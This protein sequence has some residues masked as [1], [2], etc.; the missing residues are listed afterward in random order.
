[1]YP[2]ARVPELTERMIAA[3]VIVELCGAR[4]RPMNSFPGVSGLLIDRLFKLGLVEEGRIDRFDLARAF[5][6]SDLG[7]KTL[8]F[9]GRKKRRH[10]PRPKLQNGPFSRDYAT[11]FLEHGS[12]SNFDWIALKDIAKSQQDFEPVEAR[13]IAGLVL[14]ERL[15]DRGL[16]EKGPC[17]PDYVSRGFPTGYRVTTLG[18]GI[19]QRGQNAMP[20]PVR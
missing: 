14:S 13:A 8:K 20:A 2:A 3:L 17:H 16:V 5:R 15:V 4:F 11:E 18:W 7:R 12:L 9:H 1:M 10:S 19:L 6:I